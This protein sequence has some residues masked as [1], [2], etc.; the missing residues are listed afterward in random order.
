MNTKKRND[1]IRELLKLDG[2]KVSV[3]LPTHRAFPDNKKDPIVY[4]N[5]LQ[6]AEKTLA[7][8]HP[9]REWEGQLTGLYHLLEDVDFWNHTADGLG[10]LAIGDR[11]ETFP[12]EAPVEPSFTVGETFNLLPLFMLSHTTNRA[13]LADIGR[14]RFRMFA[15]NNAQ[16]TELDP[17]NIKGSFPELFDDH[18]ANS[19]LR[20]GG[21]RGLD[22]AYHGQGG[23]PR[24]AEV[25]REKYFRYLDSG[26][27][28][29]H[30]NSGL[31]FILAGTED[32]VTQF[33]KLAKGGFYLPEAV[34]KPFEALDAPE[35]KEQLNGII[36]PYRAGQLERLNTAISNKRNSNQVASTP[37]DITQA[38][39]QGLVETLILPGELQQNQQVLLHKAAEHTILNGGTVLV[40]GNDE[41][42]VPEK[43]LALL[44]TRL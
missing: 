2:I 17:P 10:V 4:K 16:L 22:G 13:F 40:T 31:P 23:R 21:Y 28:R 15:V 42:N 14:D 27:Q 36:A 37:E 34:T 44:Y 39:E 19:T 1:T 8:K 32:S 33:M 6:E 26:F 30:D 5:L 18:D 9:R 24:Q 25:D 38:A 29:I 35:L 7:E 3:Y 12:F 20:T 11:V 43:W 41:L